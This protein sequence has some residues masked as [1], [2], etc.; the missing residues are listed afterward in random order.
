VSAAAA[1]PACRSAAGGAKR[2]SPHR[3][4]A[5]PCRWGP[6][7]DV[8]QEL[9]VTMPA[10]PS[11]QN[12]RV[13]CDAE[14]TPAPAPSHPPGS[15]WASTQAEHV[16]AK[17]RLSTLSHALEAEVIPRLVRSHRKGPSAPP[18]WPQSDI[19]S[20]VEML[21]HARDDEIGAAVAAF[22][23]RGHSVEALF[24]DLFAPAA[25]HLGQL[26]LADRCDF[27]T[28]TVCLGRL[29]RLLREWSPAFGAEVEHPPNG[30]RIL[31]AQHP[32]EQHS[33]GLSIVAEF[34]RR[35]GWE[36][37]GG[38]G[39]AVPD[40]SAQ[41]SRD[42]FDVV[43]FSVGS[44]TRIDWLRERVAQ[45]RASSRNRAV[46]VLVGGPLFVMNSGWA[47]SVGADAGAHDGGKA[48]ALAEGL[49]AA[50]H[51]QR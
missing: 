27:S 30:R 46:V 48:P 39:G 45:V 11:N 50:R 37:L 36:V 21:Q 32:D 23:R 4:L 34:F 51:V 2:R 3:S 49:L 17:H 16:D 33:F 28:V 40:P 22:H 38:V 20:F 5:V 18:R 8:T 35:D 26:W 25:R 14:G 31:L 1:H 19:E 42:W 43:G 10:G 12:P 47:D 13:D 44:Q 6:G 15:A 24:L 9:S 29:Q 41:V 7:E